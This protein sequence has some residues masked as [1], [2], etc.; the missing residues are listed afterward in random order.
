MTAITTNRKTGK[1][2]KLVLGLAAAASIATTMMPTDAE[3][4]WRGRRNWAIGAGVIGGL[5]AG[6][7]IAGA[8]S[9]GYGYGYHAAPVYSGPDCYWV[10]QRRETWD[11]YI[12]VRRV[13]V[14][15]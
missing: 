5:A 2:A 14:C 8:A 15:E 9:P 12:V 3:A 6:A 13:R 10:R 11:G 7:L 4:G 1:I